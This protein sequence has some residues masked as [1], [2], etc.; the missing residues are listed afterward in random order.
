MSPIS[1]L[2]ALS[3]F[4][5]LGYQV[6]WF[7]VFVDRFGSTNLTFALVLC[8]FIGGLGLGALLSRPIGER[9]GR[10]ASL[11]S[12]IR[13]YGALELTVTLLAA[14]TPLSALLPS[15]ILGSF[16][17]VESEGGIFEPTWTRTLLQTGLSALL[18]LLPCVAMGATYP[19]LCHAHRQQRRFPAGLYAW[20]TLGACSAVIAT[21]FLLLP[22]VGHDASFLVMLALNGGLGLLALLAP[23]WVS[24]GAEQEAP[25]APPE[26]PDSADD[27]SAAP[28]RSTAGRIVLVCAVLSGLLTGALEADMFKRLQFLECNTEAAMSFISF[29]AI[30]AIFLASTLVRI[31][32][33][34]GLVHLRVALGLASGVYFLVGSLAYRLR[35]SLEAVHADR[36]REAVDEGLALAGGVV[37]QHF[38]HGLGDVLIYT[39]I[40]VL[41]AFFLA[42]LVLPWACNLG[43]SKGLH[44]GHAYGLN[45]VAFCIG[46]VAFSW[47][48]PGVSIF[49]SLKMIHWATLTAALALVLLPGRG[50]Y[51]A[52]RIVVPTFVL[53]AG[54]FATQRGFDPSLLDEK[55]DAVR[56]PV[57]GLRSNG[58][59]TTY[60]VEHERGDLLYFDAHTMSGT[61]AASQ[62]YMRLMA[63]FPLLLAENPERALLICFGVGNTASAIAAHEAIRELDVVDLN[64][65]V[66]ASAGEFTATNHNV[67]EDPRVRLIHDDGRAFLAT[68]D[69]HYD[70]ITSEPPPPMH[71]GVV[72]LYT[73]EYYEQCLEHLTPTGRM[74][75]W[76]PVFEMP[77]EAVERSIAT[78]V[79]VFPHAML[80]VGSGK[81][82][83]LI[84]GPAPFDFDALPPR[85][86]AEPRVRRDLRGVGVDGIPQLLARIVRGPSD[87][88]MGY[89]DAP[90]LS[91]QR[92]D[93]AFLVRDVIDPPLL[94]YDP[95]VVAS[96][97]GFDGEPWGPLF[98][99]AAWIQNAAPDFPP[100]SLLSIPAEAHASVQYADTDW[101]RLEECNRRASN[102]RGNPAR[103][104][105]WLRLSLDILPAQVGAR[106]QLAL[107]L[108]SKGFH[109]EAGEAWSTCV[110]FCPRSARAHH[111][112]GQWQMGRG[113]R[114]EARKSF[115]RA[116]EL[117]PYSAAVR[118]DFAQLLRVEGER[119]LARAQLSL[120]LPDLEGDAA[121]EVRSLLERLGE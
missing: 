68:T 12:P 54:A 96:E 14:L 118:I 113:L 6:V 7:R 52:W 107:L 109:R 97:L 98:E 1:L 3:G 115:E 73:E 103:L 41:P 55:N 46:M 70:L 35:D 30:V 93:M 91:D 117:D 58:A 4:V 28:S 79:Q 110:E 32:P 27:P 13:R 53:I 19:L 50:A 49:Y 25:E 111:G 22:R 84:G 11:G 15:G 39:G 90:N 105:E 74:S 37:V 62:R 112:R 36:A 45:T 20:N 56:F 114:T 106:G 44:L 119:D 21:E 26:P 82:Y 31:L 29:W 81:N 57:R 85:F 121:D 99:N 67:A 61:S 108:E 72:R 77:K 104:E 9:L 76:L 5:S 88:R 47:I 8:N 42:S 94:P 87:L 86:A 102:Q 2:Y 75:Q 43:Q 64:E 33:R 18:V 101:A 51:G 65:N 80:Y 89:R 63:H 120:A 78:F 69:R 100:M 92:N 71:V 23:T 17:Y 83:L 34:L 66:F 59:H 60:V 40:F 95:R 24:P 48:A 38:I 16:P 116:L 10:L